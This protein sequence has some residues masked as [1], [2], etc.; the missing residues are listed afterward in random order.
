VTP[1]W[2]INH[3]PVHS[4]LGYKRY[5]AAYRIDKLEKNKAVKNRCKWWHTISCRPRV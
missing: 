1:P 2:R 4:T 5:T 3:N